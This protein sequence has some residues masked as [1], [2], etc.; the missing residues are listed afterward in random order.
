MT[1]T[2]YRNN[3]PPQYFTKNIV[4]LWSGSGVLREPCDI[5][6]PS[7]LIEADLSTIL[8]RANYMFID[9]FSRFYFLNPIIVG[10]HGLYGV[11]GTVDA[12]M[13]WREEALANTAIIAR[14]E[15]LY[16]LFLDDGVFKAYSNPIVQR[17]E[18]SGGFNTSEFILAVAGGVST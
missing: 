1:V 3:S 8:N 13:S 16:N 12:L 2:L 9:D 10:T 18:F 14:Q 6:H 7:L 4:S 17:L 15:N 11:S 5:L